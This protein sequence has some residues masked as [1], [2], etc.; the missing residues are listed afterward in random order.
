[1]KFTSNLMSGEK[2]TAG[3]VVPPEVIEQLGGGK[4]PKVVVTLNGFTYRSS[5]AKMGDLFLIP[6]S[7]ARRAEGKLEVDVPYEIEIE[8]DTAPREVEIPAELAAIFETDE[9]AKAAWD[10]MSY[11][12]QLQ[13]VIPILNAKKPETR[14]RNVDKVIAQ[15]QEKL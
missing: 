13:T 5:V 14:Q 10:A 7:K 4:H 11:S 3:I 12:K 2:D 15:L 6:A 8:I 9:T 1:M